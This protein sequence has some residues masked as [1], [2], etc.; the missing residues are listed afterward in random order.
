MKKGSFQSQSCE[1][2]Q[3]NKKHLQ[4][5]NFG[6]T[7]KKKK[8]FLTPKDN[9]LILHNVNRWGTGELWSVQQATQS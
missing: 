6:D 9:Q 1:A 8:I 2:H 7:K 4:K 3:K 5:A